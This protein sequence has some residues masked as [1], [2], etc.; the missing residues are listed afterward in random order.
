MNSFH[1]LKQEIIE[2]RIRA[3]SN[4]TIQ[5]LNYLQE[6]AENNLNNGWISVDDGKGMIQWYNIKQ[7]AKALGVCPNTFKSRY[8]PH[9]PEPQHQNGNRKLWTKQTVDDTIEKIERG[10]FTHISH[11]ES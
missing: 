6:F 4:E 5:V 2:C 7:F 9:I 3:K 1:I 11:T 10:A 8:M